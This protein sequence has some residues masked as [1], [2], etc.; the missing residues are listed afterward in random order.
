MNT[1]GPAR[2]ADVPAAGFPVRHPRGRTEGENFLH[3]VEPAAIMPIDYYLWAIL[4]PD[5][6]I[7]VDTGCSAESLGERPGR[8]LIAPVG[9]CSGPPASIGHASPMWC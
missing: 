8:T 5:R 4:G 1:A 6:V 3:P 7:V 2:G 9:D